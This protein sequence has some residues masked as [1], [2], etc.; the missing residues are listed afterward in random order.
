MTPYHDLVG[1]ISRL[2]R[3]G[4]NLPLGGFPPAPRPPITPDAPRVLIFA[5]HPD[6]ECIIGGLPL[7]LMRE[8][9]M[10]V[11][12]V[13]VT[14]GS[15]KERQAARWTELEA[16]C[17]YLGFDLIQTIPGGLERITVK[18][19]EQDPADWGRSVA[20]IAGILAEHQPRVILF[21]HDSDWNGTHIGTHYLL[22]DAL[23]Q[24]AAGFSCLVVET[25]FWGAMATPNLTVESS[26][27]DVADLMAGTSFH[28]GEVQRNPYHLLQTAWMQDNVRRGG[29]LVG[30]Q[31]G[32]APDFTFCTLYRYRRWEN[33]RFEALYT[34]G[35]S[36]PASTPAGDLLSWA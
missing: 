18:N 23:K 12:N 19:R 29:E 26:A 3:D 6:D 21:P 24:Q 15:K 33:A 27:H 4:K 32:A 5:P 20:V 35:R 13:A 16:A 8:A 11:I 1:A 31:G 9:H 22:V 10:R 28:V 30:G 2:A 36:L 14:Q 34:G 17:H 25:E 7:R